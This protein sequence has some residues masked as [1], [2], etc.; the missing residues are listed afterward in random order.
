M[1]CERGGAWRLGCQT[2]MGKGGHAMEVSVREAWREPY[3]RCE[4]AL[5]RARILQALLRLSR[6]RGCFARHKAVITGAGSAEAQSA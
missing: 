2:I 1:A 5:R 4:H 6:A 3:A